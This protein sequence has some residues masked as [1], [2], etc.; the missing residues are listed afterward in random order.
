M[1]L[2]NYDEKSFTK[3]TN[4]VKASNEIILNN[5]KEITKELDEITSVLNTPK[6]S[7]IIT[8]LVEELNEM[9]K[10]IDQKDEY[11][12]RTMTSVKNAYSEFMDNTRASVG[13][14]RG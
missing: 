14:N 9:I 5:M 2:I 3:A 13:G 4:Q 12:N 10:Y 6:S 7:I 1:A 8:K 11:F